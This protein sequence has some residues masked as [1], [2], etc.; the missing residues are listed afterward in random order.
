MFCCSSLG[1]WGLP[2]SIKKKLKNGQNDGVTRKYFK[3]LYL[4]NVDI[5]KKWSANNNL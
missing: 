5:D 3:I 4:L 2:S 1:F